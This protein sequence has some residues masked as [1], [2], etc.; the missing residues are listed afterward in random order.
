MTART[1]TRIA[2]AASALSLTLGLA[3]CGSGGSEDADTADATTTTVADETTTSEAPET[4]TTVAEETTTTL[5]NEGV[6]TE[7]SELDTLEDGVHYGY[8][9]GIEEGTVEGTPV[10]VLLFDKV[11]FLTGDD[12]TA[13]AKEDGVIPEDQLAIENDYY[14]RNNNQA[15]RR[16][17]VVPDA[18]VSTLPEGGGPGMV[19][20]GVDEVWRQPYLFKIDVGNVRGITTISSIEAVYLP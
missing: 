5:T 18:S 4:T 11:E 19:P 10:S 16:I 3:A 8:L 6:D 20:S 7:T 1:T 2:I 17:A 13:A 12:A 9:A 14:I 15:I